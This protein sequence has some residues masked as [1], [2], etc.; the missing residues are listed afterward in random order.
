M[1]EPAGIADLEAVGRL[2][3][4]EGSFVS[5]E[6][7]GSGH[8]NDTFAVT[9][10]STG[11]RRRYLQ[12]RI[13]DHVF[14]DPAAVI[15][16]IAAVTRHIR[17][18]L[19]DEGA[20]DLDRHVLTLVPARL[21]ADHAVDDDG[22][23][24]R[25]YVF[26]EGTRT[27]DIVESEAQAFETARAFGEFQRRLSDYD[28]PRLAETIPGFH[29]TPRRLATFEQSL[30]RDPVG[31]SVE[32]AREVDFLLARAG[33]AGALQGLHAHGGVPERIVHNDTKLNNL[34]L[35]RVSD[36]AVCVVDLDTVMPGLALHDFGDMVRSSA[37]RTLEDEPDLGRVRLDPVLFEALAR[38]Y[39][40]AA[41]SFLTPAERENLVTAAEVIVLEQSLRFLTDFLEGDVYYRTQRKTQNLDRCRT[42]VRLLASLEEQGDRL[43]RRVEEIAREVSA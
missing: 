7:Y 20:T 24:W 33:K 6:P 25:T 3:V 8:I 22:R 42:Q 15:A 16:N 43:R 41:G 37:V 2:F 35:D 29:D 38:G 23:F 13:N 40:S 27:L 32:A 17:A 10:E 19:A 4:L 1:S 21:G 12:Q 11:H 31:R 34:L 9:Y 36:R 30:R 5:G 39:L 14:A 28:G 18:R 26:V